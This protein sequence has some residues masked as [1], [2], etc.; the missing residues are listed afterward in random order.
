MD[1]FCCL[2][3]A[4]ADYG[5]TTSKRHLWNWRTYGAAYARGPVTWLRLERPEADVQNGAGFGL[6]VEE[7]VR[8][9]SLI[10]RW[11]A[12][13]AAA[14]GSP[15]DRAQQ[16]Q[17]RQGGD[18]ENMSSEQEQ[19]LRP[20]AWILSADGE[21]EPAAILKLLE[22]PGEG[23]SL[24]LEVAAGP[25]PAL[26]APP[27]DNSEAA[28]L[29]SP[30]APSS[31][32]SAP[33]E[34]VEPTDDWSRRICAEG[35]WIEM[36]YDRHNC[37]YLPMCLACEKWAT[38]E[39]LE[40]QRHREATLHWRG[41]ASS[42]STR[43]SPSP[44]MNEASGRPPGATAVRPPPPS[45]SAQA[46]EAM[47]QPSVGVQRPPPPS[48]WS[49]QSPPKAGAGSMNRPPL[50]QVWHAAAPP[51]PLS[52]EA[53]EAMPGSSSPS[54]S[55]APPP[56]RASGQP[57]AAKAAPKSPAARSCAAGAST[58][59]G[60]V[61]ALWKIMV[62]ENVK[63]K[64]FA[65]QESAVL[66]EA[67][68]GASAVQLAPCE[69]LS[70]GILRMYVRVLPQFGWATS[71]A[72]V[73]GYWQH[74]LRLVVGN[75]DKLG[76]MD[77]EWEAKQELQIRSGSALDSTA[78]A[79]MPGQSRLV[80]VGRAREME[81]S[82][83]AYVRVPVITK[84]VAMT[85][86][87]LKGWVT[88]DASAMN[89][90][91]FLTLIEDQAKPASL[92]AKLSPAQAKSPPPQAKPMPV[93]TTT[94]VV[95]VKAPPAGLAQPPSPKVSHPVASPK[96][97]TSKYGIGDPSSGDYLVKATPVIRRPPP[98]PRG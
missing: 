59:R 31:A 73:D 96:S 55:K 28:A 32:Q 53:A 10:S 50:P 25:P 72:S 24:E 84:K 33:A 8:E 78:I 82:G 62:H 42:S 77:A 7:R 40:S 14:A 37:I 26:P 38:D 54:S 80:Q 13:A 1:T 83:D 79:R 47:Q 95:E 20:E 67:A 23:L 6:Q 86:C 69:Q 36:R 63:V 4:F 43:H 68:P 48:T 19:I 61:G 92:E 85:R 18:S 94:P 9:G 2:C 35:M 89:G 98:P 15:A 64:E 39:H 87:A 70:N 3:S 44:A 93:E 52:P 66:G 21:A 51:P 11:A 27:S 22:E 65:E 41:A 81:K 76:S 97:C 34:R 56:S 5:Y 12:V 91:V 90:P 88:F 30:N 74:L 58:A 57:A 49:V 16:R 29:P 17:L 60:W 75:D 46:A 71:C 45:P